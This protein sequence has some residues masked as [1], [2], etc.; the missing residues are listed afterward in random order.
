MCT[1][2]VYTQWWRNFSS[3]KRL[4]FV[5]NA[6]DEIIK[7]PFNH[8]HHPAI[9]VELTNEP[10]IGYLDT[11]G[12][13]NLKSTALSAEESDPFVTITNNFAF[14]AT[15]FKKKDKEMRFFVSVTDTASFFALS[16]S[17]PCKL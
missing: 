15:L 12:I 4:S 14:R 10:K 5:K 9:I 6:A 11:F 16:F 3:K 8:T 1:G 13:E 17:Q 2:T 7:R